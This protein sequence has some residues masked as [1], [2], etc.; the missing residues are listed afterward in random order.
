M[1]QRHICNR[2]VKEA[3]IQVFL[4]THTQ[5]LLLELYCSPTWFPWQPKNSLKT[6]TASCLSSLNFTPHSKCHF[7]DFAF[8][9]VHMLRQIHR[10]VIHPHHFRAVHFWVNYGNSPTWFLGFVWNRQGI[11]EFFPCN[12]QQWNYLGFGGGFSIIYRHLPPLARRVLAKSTQRWITGWAMSFCKVLYLQNLCT[13]DP[14]IRVG[15]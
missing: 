2:S 10:S 12:S 6:S 14:A 13:R 11:V 8:F 9:T 7:F 4:N 3:Y 15:K 5:K 1:K